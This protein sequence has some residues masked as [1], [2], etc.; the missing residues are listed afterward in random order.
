M[1]MRH[2]LPTCFFALTL[3]TMRAFADPAPPTQPAVEAPGTAQ[4]HAVIPMA[5]EDGEPAISRKHSDTAP[6][7]ATLATVEVHGTSSDATIGAAQA[8]IP[9]S[10]YVVHGE[11]F[12]QRAVNNLAD[13]LRYVPGVMAQSNAGSDDIVLSIRGSNLNSLSY[14]NSG[15]AL[16]Q[17]GLPVTT[18]DGNNHNRIV[19]PLTASDVIVANGINALTYGASDLGGATNFISR[20]ALNSDPRQLSFS[21]GSYGL[22]E[23]RLSAG[24][25]SGDLDGMVTLDDKHFDSYRKHSQQNRDSLYANG[26]WKV[27]DNL[28]LRAF[29]TY[30]N[31]RQQ[32]PGALTRAQFNSDPWQADPAY[33]A[34]NHQLNVKTDRLAT[35]GTWDINADSRLEFG[36]SYEYQQLFHPIVDVFVPV[37]PGPN[38]PL[39][40]VF[41]LLIDTSQRTTSSM[42]RYH[43]TRGN[44]DV[45]AGIVLAHT[46]EQGGNYANDVGQRGGL[47]DIVNKRASNATAFVIDRWKFTRDWTLVYGA[48]GVSTYLD[49]RQIDGVDAGNNQPRNQKNRFSSFNPRV[50]IIHALTPTSEAYSSV[51]RLYQAPNNFDLDNARMERGPHANLDAMHGTAYEA[52]LRGSSAINTQA[53][54]WRWN[55]SAYY[56]QIRNEILSVDDP[57]A[58]GLSLT[59][60]IA[61]TTHAGVEALVTSSFPLGNSASRIEPLVSATW[62]DFSFDHDPNYRNNH[63][64]SAPR[65]VLHSEVMYRNADGF[66]AGPT[67]DVVGWRYADFTNSYR[68]GAYALMG[69]RAGIKRDRWELFAELDNAFNRRYAVSVG[70]SNQSNPDDAALNP[71]APRSLYVG[72]RINY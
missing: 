20:T 7:L 4:P 71:G 25:V 66:Y 46:T 54:R 13:A 3:L 53:P 9:G 28:A 51:G 48:Q 61:R 40:K 67:F 65:Y 43:V 37:G 19:D 30:I 57:N 34:G 69:L 60:N 58:P 18:A 16:F 22:T 44:H 41:S 42:A 47:Q 45:L 50:G 12:Q 1:K 17:D 21:G 49:D 33:A 23:G 29:A 62:N 70:V 2:S 39:S 10:V 15:V 32:L 72:M 14:D 36:V 55:L 68:V 5:D 31:N 8:K 35:T 11:T 6:R 52:G 63:L 64:P 59:S 27:S 38:P 24:G 56:E 26:G